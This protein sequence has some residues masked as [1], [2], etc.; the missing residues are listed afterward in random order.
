MIQRALTKYPGRTLA[1][2]RK[3]SEICEQTGNQWDT[4][5]PRGTE[6]RQGKDKKGLSLLCTLWLSLFM[7]MGYEC[8]I[9]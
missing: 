8:S 5:Y 6:E 9:V 3:P 2:V 7:R 4:G 1:P